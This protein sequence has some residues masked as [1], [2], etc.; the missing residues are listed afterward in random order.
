MEHTPPQTKQRDLKPYLLGAA[1]S[2]V[3]CLVTGG[4]VFVAGAD[5][6]FGVAALG[7]LCFWPVFAFLYL[8]LQIV[9]RFALRLTWKNG[10]R[11][12]WLALNLPAVFLILL[13]GAAALKEPK[14]AFRRLLAN[15]IPNSVKIK[16]FARWQGIGEP[17]RLRL[18]F[19]VH[20]NE[21]Q[22]LLRAGGYTRTNDVTDENHPVLAWLRH[23]GELEI[24]AGGDSPLQHYVS[25]NDSWRNL[26]C[27]TNRANATAFFLY[28]RPDH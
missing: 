14:T 28:A 6:D 1:L 18:T 8:A 5:W 7:A 27:R 19:E 3:F 13:A 16:Q 20:Q 10:V 24:E 22:N 17:M 4:R 9:L 25:T 26:Y 2:Y 15:P 12:D 21:L 11:Y 23:Q